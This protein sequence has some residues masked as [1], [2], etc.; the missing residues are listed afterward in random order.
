MHTSIFIW[1]GLYLYV[2]MSIYSKSPS[3]RH[4]HTRALHI[5]ILAYVYSLWHV[6]LLS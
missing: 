4:T 1:R 6:P 2:L 3:F 5:H